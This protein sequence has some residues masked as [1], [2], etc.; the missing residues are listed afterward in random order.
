MKRAAGDTV[1]E[2]PEPGQ[3]PR[4]E[5]EAEPGQDPRR[6]PRAPHFP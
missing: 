5:A 6:G 3:D 2:N 1:S 4:R